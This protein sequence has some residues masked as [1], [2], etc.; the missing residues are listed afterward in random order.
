MYFRCHCLLSFLFIAILLY[1]N[2]VDL[3]FRFKQKNV[4][5]NNFCNPPEKKVMIIPV[6]KKTMITTFDCHLVVTKWNF[7]VEFFVVWSP[8]S[9][10]YH[11]CNAPVWILWHVFFRKKII[12]GTFLL[13]RIYIGF[14]I[15]ET[16]RKVRR[17]YTHQFVFFWFVF[18]HYQIKS[19]REKMLLFHVEMMIIMMIMSVS[20]SLSLL[21]MKYIKWLTFFTL[22]FLNQEFI[23]W[24]V[25]FDLIFRLFFIFR[26]NC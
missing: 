24:F 6:N 9:E 22:L 19:N 20:L 26:P 18:C 21:V 7:A 16:T 11:L 5:A 4:I 12:L 23:D 17:I 25:L 13:F 10:N 2:Q 1:K 15:I 14:V 8:Y 3:D